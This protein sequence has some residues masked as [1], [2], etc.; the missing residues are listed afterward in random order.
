MLI[1]GWDSLI[2]VGI[3]LLFLGGMIFLLT[4]VDIVSKRV[5]GKQKIKR[6]K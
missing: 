3:F 2:D 6:R 1:L 5:P 4:K